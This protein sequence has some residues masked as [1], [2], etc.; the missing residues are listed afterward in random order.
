[1]S[2]CKNG[3]LIFISERMNNLFDMSVLSAAD[4]KV[5]REWSNVSCSYDLF[6]TN[7]APPYLE[8]IF[9]F[10]FP[11][12]DTPLHASSKDIQ[13]YLMALPKI[14]KR[15]WNFLSSVTLFLKKNPVLFKLSK[16]IYTAYY[17]R[18]I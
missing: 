2:I 14:T 8:N 15:D 18:F 3:S 13:N 11:E 9:K 5:V 17:N 6:S 1:M 4:K 16:S 10:L 12:H 7:V